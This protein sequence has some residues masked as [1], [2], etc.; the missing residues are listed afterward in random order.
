MLVISG[1]AESTKANSA[2]NISKGNVHGF[3]LFSSNESLEE[4]LDTI[5]SYMID[6]GWDNIV[7][8][9][10][11]LIDDIS[12]FRHDVILKAIEVAQANGLAGVINNDP[13]M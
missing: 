13:V 7:I 1:V 11:E 9:E 2:N 12:A 8:E 5:E 4:Q 10:Q 6:R 3:N